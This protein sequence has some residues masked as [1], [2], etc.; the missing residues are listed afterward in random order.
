MDPDDR[1]IMQSQCTIIHR[2]STNSTLHGSK[3]P[4]ITTPRISKLQWLEWIW[5]GSASVFLA[6]RYDHQQASQSA[7][8]CWPKLNELEG[9]TVHVQL[10]E[11]SGKWEKTS[12]H[13]LCEKCSFDWFD[14]PQSVNEQ[15]VPCERCELVK[16]WDIDFNLSLQKMW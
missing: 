6:E 12:V 16:R 8:N 9:V 13:D 7:C 15:S 11:Y 5:L 14:S 10:N 3:N 1:V 2:P 4:P